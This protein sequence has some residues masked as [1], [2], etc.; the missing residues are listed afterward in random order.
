M[1]NEQAI[2]S[3][4]K[5]E[6]IT[7]TECFRIATKLSLAK[8]K[9][10]GIFAM[11]VA[12]K[13]HN[14]KKINYLR[15]VGIGTSGLLRYPDKSID[16]INSYKCSKISELFFLA[17]ANQ[18]CDVIKAMVELGIDVNIKNAK[19]GNI[20]DK[21]VEMDNYKLCKLADSLGAYINPT[22]G[23]KSTAITSGYNY[24]ICKLVKHAKK[25]RKNNLKKTNPIVEYLYPNGITL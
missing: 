12:I 20:F 2:L 4:I 19:G 15:V 21:A 6:T 14:K 16:V 13:D 25:K 1:K 17:I 24:K 8:F 10:W 5:S 11:L 9:N 22:Y 23:L 3:L 7:G 18:Y